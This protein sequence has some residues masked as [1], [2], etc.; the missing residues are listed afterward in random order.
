MPGIRGF[1]VFLVACVSGFIPPM[2]SEAQDRP[3][4]AIKK[5]DQDGDGQISRDEWLKGG[6]IFKQI[7]TDNNGFLTLEELRKQ[8]A[9]KLGASG[10]EK[11]KNAG[12]ALTREGQVGLHAI[13]RQAICAMYRGTRCGNADAIEYGLFETGLKPRFPENAR[14]RGIDD[15]Y[16]MDYSSKRPTKSYHGGIDIPAPTGSPI[17]AAATGI[18]V[19]KYGASNSARGIEI[20]L[21]HSPDDTELPYWVY[22][23]YTHFKKMPKQEIGQRVRMGEVLGPTGNSGLKPGTNQQNHRRRP[24]IHF[25]AFYTKSE[26]FVELEKKISVIIPVNFR[27]MDPLALYRNKTPLDSQTMK[28]L[29]DAEKR[30]P[31]SVMFEDG[32]ISPN[33]A[34]IIWPYTCERV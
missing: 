20:V 29:P 22:T 34:K 4:R 15:H 5:M 10:L 18:V 1:A 8:V 16:A 19:A 12:T 7:D 11:Q 30:I 13:D 32:Q 27:W 3:S 33:D 21:R 25:A 9:R 23:Q 31:V 24:A 2:V 6:K 28:D 17:I 14:C 26:K